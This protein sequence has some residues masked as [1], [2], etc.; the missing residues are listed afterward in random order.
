MIENERFEEAAEAVSDG[1]VDP[2]TSGID[3]P[4]TAEIVEVTDEEQDEAAQYLEDLQRLAADFENYRKRA[5]R[6]M[7]ENV[8]RASTRVVQQLLPVLDSLDLAADHDPETPGEEKVLAGVNGTRNQLLE[9][10]AKEGLEPIPALG[11]KFDPNVHEA[12]SVVD[13][14]DDLV[15]TQ[16]M[17]RGYL[18]QGRVLRPAMVIVSHDESA[19]PAEGEA[20]ENDG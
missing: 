15:V 6:D 16:E 3:A 11:E 18:L 20:A 14:G 13:H 17:R 8:A 19:T 7:A 5:Q 2:G 9:I 12:V 1:V 10:L 4:Q